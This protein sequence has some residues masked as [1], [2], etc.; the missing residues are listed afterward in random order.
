MILGVPL[1]APSASRPSSSFSNIDTRR[2]AW[3][4]AFVIPK[5]SLFESRGDEEQNKTKKKTKPCLT[6]RSRVDA[7]LK[8][9]NL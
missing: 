3:P 9:K 1:Q 5:S 8:E 7:D 6:C 4:T 2:E